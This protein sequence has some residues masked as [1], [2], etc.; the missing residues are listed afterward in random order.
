LE[1]LPTYIPPNHTAW[2]G[3]MF[4]PRE[5]NLKTS[6]CNGKKHFR[7]AI[8]DLTF[9]MVSFCIKILIEQQFMESFISKSHCGRLSLGIRP[10]L[11]S[12]FSLSRN[13]SVFPRL[14]RKRKATVSHIISPK[15]NI[16]TG[17]PCS[18]SHLCF[19]IHGVNIQFQGQ[20]QKLFCFVLFCFP[21][22]CN[23]LRISPLST[24]HVCREL[25]IVLLLAH[26]QVY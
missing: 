11:R 10:S 24:L 17:N 8:K 7:V 1:N 15:E 3:E 22:K 2:C 23:L 6:S 14:K 12:L 20:V 19:I 26:N 4:L 13:K 25:H 21:K 9:H 5:P 16:L 18:F